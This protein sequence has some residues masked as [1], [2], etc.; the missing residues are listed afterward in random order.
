M[1]ALPA[2]LFPAC[3]IF[4]L[5]VIELWQEG[6]GPSGHRPYGQLVMLSGA[7]SLAV[8]P[9][10]AGESLLKGRAFIN[11]QGRACNQLA[12]AAGNKFSRNER[13]RG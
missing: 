5:G 2:D 9:V 12:E 1:A 8:V 13:A 10:G 7:H 3:S 11:V 4:E 6:Q